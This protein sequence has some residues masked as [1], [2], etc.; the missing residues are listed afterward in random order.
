M[1]QVITLA[2]KS[3]SGKSTLIRTLDPKETFIIN[4]VDKDL[5]YPGWTNDYNLQNK[6]IIATKNYSSIVTALQKID[7]DMPH[8]KKVFIDDIG[9][10]T[11]SELMDRAEEKNFDKYVE[12]AQHMF[13][14][15]SAAKAMR[16]DIV[17]ILAFHQEDEEDLYQSADI[18]IPGKMM[19]KYYHP[20][21]LSTVCVFTHVEFDQDSEEEKYYLVVKKTKKYPLAKTP[22]GM[23]DSRMI[24]ADLQKLLDRIN[25]YNKLNVR[26]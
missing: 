16:S 3:N 2:G 10:V 22:I 4:V 19:K 17:V 8:I 24:D 12:L 25:E 1:A 21:E 7:K 15:V 5:P 23:F 9:Y 6:N 18:K 13:Y 20:A 26:Q 11:N 14:I